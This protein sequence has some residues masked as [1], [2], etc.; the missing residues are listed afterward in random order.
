MRSRFKAWLFI[1]PLSAAL[2]WACTRGIIPA[3]GEKRFVGFS[4]EKELEIGKQANKEI[5]TLFGIYEDPKLE[6]YVQEVGQ[7]VLAKSHLR[8]PEM[9]QEIRNTPITFRVLD[10]PTVNAMALPGGYIYVTRGLLAHLNSEDQLAAVLGHEIGHIAAR[11]AARRAW[12]QQLGQGLLLGGAIL[13]QQVLG[14]PAEQMLNLGSMA[15]QMIFLRYSREDELDADRLSVE[16]SS[17]AGYQAEDVVGF[18]RALSRIT[19]KEGQGLPNF[20]ST[21]PD[22]GDRLTRVKELAAG[23][24]AKTAVR[25]AD[26]GAYYK[27]IDGIILGEDPRQ[28]FVERSVFYHPEL[29]FRFPVP[30]GFRVVNQPTQVIMVDNQQRAMIGFTGSGEKSAR[31]VASKFLS[32][33]GLRVLESGPARSDGLPAF[34]AVADAQTQNGQIVRLL[35]YFIEYRGRVYQFVAYTAPQAFDRFRNLFLQ[36]MRG[37]GEIDNREIL[38]RQPVRIRLQPVT[39]SAPFKALI[40]RDL[41]RDMTA[42]DLA[43]LNQVDLNEE[44]ERGRILKLPSFS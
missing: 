22:P 38:N 42:E 14:L 33:P 10:S 19:E 43:I 3:T 40:P 25:E 39:R 16:Y 35:T 17:L 32:Q 31:A 37:F 44:I 6:R 27:A 41:P 12:Q 21:H 24:R 8:R 5:A 11:H 1:V 9:D 23:W 30:Q 29:R 36:P 13:G 7:R 20:L 28:G 4:W 2:A 18:F 15:A 34:A 26:R